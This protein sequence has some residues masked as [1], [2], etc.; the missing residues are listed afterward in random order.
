MGLVYSREKLATLKG[1]K[2]HGK[3]N[4]INK[5]IQE[6]PDFEYKRLEPSM[7]DECIAV[8]DEWKEGQGPFR[9]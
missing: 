9:N 6:H 3:R 5:F 8:Y 4:H 2:L 1:K 7:Y